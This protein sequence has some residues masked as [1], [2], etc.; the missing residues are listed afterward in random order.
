VVGTERHRS[1]FNPKKYGARI[2]MHSPPIFAKAPGRKFPVL[3]R[4]LP[5]CLNRAGAF[6]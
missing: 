6:R 3:T 1:F 4:K 5:S 2:L